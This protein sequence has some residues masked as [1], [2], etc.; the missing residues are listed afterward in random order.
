MR[1]KTIFTLFMGFI[2][3]FLIGAVYFWGYPY[4]QGWR[5]EKQSQKFLEEYTRPYKEDI[6]GGATPEETWNM[7]LDALRKEDMDLAAKYFEVK[8]QEKGLEWLNWVK[9][10]NEL[11]N[12]VNDL[13]VSPLH[14]VVTSDERIEYTVS[15]LDKIAKAYVIFLKNTFTNIWKISSL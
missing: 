4:Y 14:E 11:N 9:D 7:F 12:M 2:I 13:T 3:I 1:K 5:I 6:Y 10:N 15:G 8:E